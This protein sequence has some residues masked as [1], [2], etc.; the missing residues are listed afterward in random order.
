[1]AG[2][3]VN[4]IMAKLWQL[5]EIFAS[6]T[7][8]RNYLYNATRNAAHNHLRNANRHG[9]TILSVENHTLENIEEP[10]SDSHDTLCR[11]LISEE[12]PNIMQQLPGQ[13][14]IVIR[15]RMAEGLSTEE[16]AKQLNI[17]QNTVN[18]HFSTAKSMLIGLLNQKG[19]GPL[20]IALCLRAIFF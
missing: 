6:Y 9:T 16:I 12:L 19:W 15:L 4:D 5:K 11:K 14:G 2:D 10:N 20:L 8:V 1:V 13:A 7:H 18:K 17:N 3:I